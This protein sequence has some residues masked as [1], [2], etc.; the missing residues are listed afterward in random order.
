ME[1]SRSRRIDAG[2]RDVGHDHWAV[3]QANLEKMARRRRTLERF[4]IW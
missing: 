3:E 4:R 2:V 1:R